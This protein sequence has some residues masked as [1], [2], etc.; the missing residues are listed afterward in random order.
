MA[1]RDGAEA[2][3][4]HIDKVLAAVDI[5]SDAIYDRSHEWHW[6]KLREYAMGLFARA[7]FK[8]NDRVRLTK[9]PIITETKSPGWMGAKH[10]LVKGAMATVRYVDYIDGH[11]CAGVVFDEESFIHPHTKVV[12]PIEL[13][14]RHTFTF[15][16][17][18]I[19]MPMPRPSGTP[20]RSTPK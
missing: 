17:G 6:K 7:P 16:E 9:T 1:S 14:G 18:D 10:F 20:D 13:E 3:F 11:F 19:D 12:T 5:M 15:W 4:E 2:S 8:V